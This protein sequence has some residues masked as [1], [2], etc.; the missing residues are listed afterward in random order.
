MLKVAQKIP[1]HISIIM[2]GNGRW[3]R[4]KMLPHA[5][6]H[7][8]GGEVL[9]AMVSHCAKLGVEYLTVYALSTENLNRPEEEVS[10]LMGLFV[11]N[12]QTKVD[13]LKKNNVK[14]RFIGDRSFLG[15]DLQSLMHQAEENTATC[16]GLTLVIAV[17]YG[18]R[19]EIVHAIKEISSRIAK[20]EMAVDDISEKLLEDSLYTSGIPD[21]DILLRPGGEKRIS[22]YLL[23]Q[24]AY[25]ELI[26]TDTLWPD[27]KQEDLDNAIEEYNK[28]ERRF[29]KLSSQ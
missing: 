12:L 6:G 15:E 22:N 3:A 17:C 18:G 9:E 10:A 13:D 11:S 26:F 24:C 1:K 25:T 27:F 20:G 29:G 4:K 23:W 2:D 5:V 19:A 7:K 8:K 16:D 21:P 14:L 28:R